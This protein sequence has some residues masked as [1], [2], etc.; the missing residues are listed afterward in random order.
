MNMIEL[1]LIFV[2]SSQSHLAIYLC[3]NRYSF[4][5]LKTPKDTQVE[6]GAVIEIIY[7]FYCTN[8]KM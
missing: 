7:N 4:E 1:W 2:A 8:L 6:L 3:F 5:H